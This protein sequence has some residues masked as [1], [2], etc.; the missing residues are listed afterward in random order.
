MNTPR[1]E[2]KKRAVRER[3]LAEAQRLFLARGV[4]AVSA[5]EIAEAADVAAGTFF[6]HFPTKDALVGEL[7]AGVLAPLARC[8][9]PAPSAP[10]PAERAAAFFAEAAGVLGRARAE[11]GELLVALLRASAV[12]E[13]ALDPGARLRRA[14]SQLLFES[15]RRGEVRCEGEAA[16]LAEL[17]VGA[18]SAS[19][20][21]WLRDPRYPLEQRMAQLAG[22]VAGALGM[23]RVQ[24]A[25]TLQPNQ[26]RAA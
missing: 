24:P 18:F 11:S 3:L 6:N 21:H 26:E 13:A 8:L 25:S 4:A 20:L 23:A 16:F 7:A 14:W 22:F 17:V 5:A 1:R 10:P 2:R 9:E 12:G 15:Q 19:L